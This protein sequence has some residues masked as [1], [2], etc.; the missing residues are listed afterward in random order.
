MSILSIFN[1]G[2]ERYPALTGV[3]AVG[4]AAVFFNHLPFLLGFRFTVDVIVLF[5]V[6]SG[7]LIVY[8]Y[9]RT[10]PG[11]SLNLFN[12][13]VN[14]FARIY[15][16]YFLI[17][18]IAIY[19][20]HDFR[21]LL[22]FKNYT[23]THS[24]FH[25]IKDVLVQPS[26]SLTVEECF[27]LLAPLIMLLIRKFNYY[28]SLAFAV[29]LLLIALM[30][31]IGPFSFLH[32]PKFV[33]DTTFFGYFFAFYAGA[34]L[35]LLILNKEKEGSVKRKGIAFTLAGSA[36][37]LLALG[38]M[39]YIYLFPVG[40]NFWTWICLNNFILPVPVTALYFGL[41]TEN[42]LLARVLSGKI[43]GL[44]G[45]TSYAFYLLHQL[46]IDL[47]ALPYLQKY[48]DGHHNLFVIA[49]FIMVQILA[50]LIF[51]FYEE[52]LNKLIRSKVKLRSNNGIKQTS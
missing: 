49:S 1:I 30:I 2:K 13:F 42:T 51:V 3:R 5:F 18:S 32:T 34:W 29:V 40:E 7:F 16:V 45:R 4:A 15:P 23:L 8:I 47:I 50:L 46:F 20:N 48:F 14:R 36:G 21:P 17:V 12:Y 33:F 19:C 6:L 24:L 22:L 28:V 41:I 25:N 10:T 27:Y 31:S 38:T 9:Y 26:W 43:F 37:T 39:A 35:A 52:P 44:L 11:S